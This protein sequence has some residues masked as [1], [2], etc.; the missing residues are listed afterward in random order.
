MT[1]AQQDILHEEEEFD[2]SHKIE[3]RKLDSSCA[4]ALA[5]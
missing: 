2:Y 4:N 5:W 3:I 1:A